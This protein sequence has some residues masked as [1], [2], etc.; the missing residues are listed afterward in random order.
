MLFLA[1]HCQHHPGGGLQPLFMLSNFSA[2]AKPKPK[3]AQLL[4]HAAAPNSGPKFWHSTLKPVFGAGLFPGQ[5]TRPWSG[6]CAGLRSVGSTLPRHSSPLHAFILLHHGSCLGKLAVVCG[7]FWVGL[8]SAN[9][10]LQRGRRLCLSCFIA[11][12]LLYGREREMVSSRAQFISPS[13]AELHPGSSS[14]S[15]STIKG[16]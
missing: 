15:P 2:A 3:W 16:V 11:V 4:C 1:R 6:A 12:T 10:S 9:C 5:I 13:W 8:F 7:L 14:F